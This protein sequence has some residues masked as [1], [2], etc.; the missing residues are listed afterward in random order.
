MHI[1]ELPVRRLDTNRNRRRYHE[2]IRTDTLHCS[3]YARDLFGLSG[4]RTLASLRERRGRAKPDQA[5]A[6]LVSAA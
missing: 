1:S 4:S 6:R 3:P 5:P 2:S